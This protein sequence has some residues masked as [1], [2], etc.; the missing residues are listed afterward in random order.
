MKPA[1]GDFSFLKRH[2]YEM[3]QD[4]WDT[5][6]SDPS[7]IEYVKN[8]SP[9]EAWMFSDN[10]IANKIMNSLAYKDRHSGASAACTM[11]AIEY[12]FHHGW[13]SFLTTCST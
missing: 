1:I 13:D 8:K 4:A 9:D 3:Y 6:N 11:R 7:F 2:E 5:V 10:P 12:I